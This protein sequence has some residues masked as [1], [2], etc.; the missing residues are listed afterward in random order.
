MVESLESHRHAFLESLRVRSY[1][2]ATLASRRDGVGVFFRF[3]FSRGMDDVRAV[4]CETVREYQLWL[5]CQRAPRTGESWSRRTLH[6]RVTT[7]RLFFAY[8]EKTDAILLNPCV[9]MILPKMEERL[10]R[11]VLTPAE[12]CAV[13]S[14]PDTQTQRGIRDKAILELFYS[15][16]I[17][18]E[19]MASLQIYD[20]DFRDGFLR[21]NQGK[22]AKDRMTPLGKMA[23]ESVRRYLEEVRSEWVKSS[24]QTALWLTVNKP[25]VPLKS[26]MIGLLV[27]TYAKGIGITKR[28]T[29]H[30]WRHS[31]ATHMLGGGSNVAEVQRLLGHKSLASTQIY[32][33]VSIPEIKQAFGEAHPRANL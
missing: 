16:G 12:A 29:A 15:T 14:A 33:H 32:L 10:P 3:L 17:R 1:S 22:Y 8:L 5:G 24:A 6:S 30:V 13:L 20:V 19:E 21:V 9:G 4:T 31:F 11:H 18:R 23:C 26:Q 27:K 2:A 28:I 25:H 7:L